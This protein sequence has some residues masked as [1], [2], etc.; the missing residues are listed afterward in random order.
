MPP[1]AL[2]G[3]RERSRNRQGEYQFADECTATGE[4]AECKRRQGGDGNLRYAERRQRILR[5]LDLVSSV[6]AG[7]CECLAD[8]GERTQ[9][10]PE[11]RLRAGLDLRAIGSGKVSRFWNC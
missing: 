3:R 1:S 4:G 6:A 11:S 5:R 8:H 9:A 10:V 2:P 7:R